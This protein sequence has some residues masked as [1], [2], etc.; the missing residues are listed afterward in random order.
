MILKKIMIFIRNREVLKCGTGFGR[1]VKF[2]KNRLF[3]QEFVDNY[4]L[5][6]KLVWKT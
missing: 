6:H 2:K 4:T 5:F 3:S 1:L